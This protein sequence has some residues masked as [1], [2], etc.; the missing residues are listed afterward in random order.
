MGNR[1]ETALVH[2]AIREGYGD[3]KG[4]VNVPMYLSSTF[5]QQ[6]MDEFG[7]YDYARSGNPTRAALEKE[8][9]E[10][11]GGDRGFAFATGMRLFPRA[12][13]CYQ[14]AIISSSQRMCTEERT[15]L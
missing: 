1:I 13:C 8:I 10:L 7:E 14:K 2:G 9:A 12:L 3:K 11:E 5:H 15:A 4:A 6:S